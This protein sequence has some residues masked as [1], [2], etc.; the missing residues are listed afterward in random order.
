MIA[1]F[2]VKCISFDEVLRGLTSDGTGPAELRYRDQYFL[3]GSVRDVRFY[4]WDDTNDRH[5]LSLNS[6]VRMSQ[7]EMTSWGQGHKVTW[8]TMNHASRSEPW[9]PVLREPWSLTPCVSDLSYSPRFMRC[10]VE[11]DWMV[12]IPRNKWE[13]FN[14]WWLYTVS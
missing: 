3:G 1:K 8:L 13:I 4:Y 9:S 7:R 14:P 5:I 12:M 6:S 11:H 2:I 10:V